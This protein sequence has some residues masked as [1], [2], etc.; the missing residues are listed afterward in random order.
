[1]SLELCIL[2][3]GSGGNC[4]VLRTPTGLL[5][6]DAGIGPRTAAARLAASGRRIS[7]GHLAGV[8]LTH[9]DSDHFNANW[10]RLLSRHGVPIHCHASRADDVH[11]VA[12][13]IGV[14][15]TVEPFDGD[16]FE[17]LPGLHCDPLAFA[18]DADGSHGFVIDGFGARIGYAT[19]L[20][21]VPADLIE[22]FCD[23]DVIAIESNY[24]QRMQIDS[25]RPWFLKRRIMSGRGHLSNQ[26]AYD[27]VRRIFNRCQ[28]LGHAPPRHVVLLHRSRECN[29]PDVLRRFFSRDAR[30]ASRLI[31]TEQHAPTAWIR[32]AR[33]KPFVGEQM[34]LAFG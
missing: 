27:A 2:A 19:D 4:T 5:L 3:S 32:A 14:A 10:L 29:C 1:M 23:L 13:R 11:R 30:L 7:L 8:C 15:V 18:H 21:H 17:P 24:D 9:L 16:P 31:L 26:Q 12:E 28:S 22:R 20:G 34:A 25:S 6:I 33:E